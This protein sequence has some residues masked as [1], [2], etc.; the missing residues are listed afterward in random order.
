MRTG[1]RRG[2][3]TNHIHV[4]YVGSGWAMARMPQCARPRDHPA[5][6]LDQS[7]GRAPWFVR[8]TDA[9]RVADMIDPFSAHRPEDPHSG[10]GPATALEK[11]AQNAHP[12]PPIVDGA[13][14]AFGTWRR[15]IAEEFAH[16]EG[17]SS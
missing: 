8:G 3:A 2:R 16:Q 17:D 14:P 9:Q 12:A 10:A 5:R 4:V 1:S 6:A 15:R 11:A 7:I 13:V